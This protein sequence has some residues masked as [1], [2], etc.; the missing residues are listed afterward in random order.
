MNNNNTNNNN[1]SMYVW[2]RY[3]CVGRYIYE[4]IWTMKYGQCMCV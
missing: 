1:N 3:K 4:C 2:G